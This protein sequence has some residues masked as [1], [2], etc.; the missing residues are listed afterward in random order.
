MIIFIL[1]IKLKNYYMYFK[2]TL[3]N[4]QIY[5]EVLLRLKFSLFFFI[6]NNDWNECL[7]NN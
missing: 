3:F 2:C 6:S 5:K 7:N 4:L 1:F